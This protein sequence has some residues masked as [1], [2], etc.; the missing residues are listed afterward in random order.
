MTALGMTID[1]DNDHVYWL[2]K[3][4]NG[5]S[6]LYRKHIESPAAVTTWSNQLASAAK[7][8]FL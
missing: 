4:L 3:K 5:S 7:G 6:L 1:Y 8:M 2:V